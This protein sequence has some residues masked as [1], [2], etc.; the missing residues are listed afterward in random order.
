VSEPTGHQADGVKSTACPRNAGLAPPARWALAVNHVP[1]RS[2]I[3]RS[4][5]V[6][7]ITSDV[8]CPITPK[9]YDDMATV[10]PHRC[11]YTQGEIALEPSHFGR[12]AANDRSIARSTL[13][14]MMSY[15]DVN[16]LRGRGNPRVIAS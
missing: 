11:H 2:W 9:D 16:L 7:A 5:S 10:A 14:R 13:R 6:V 1:T 15:S 3:A 8:A 12:S 4:S